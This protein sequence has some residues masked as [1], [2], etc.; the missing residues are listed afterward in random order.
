MLASQA[1]ITRCRS[2]FQPPSGVDA[3][4]TG[5]AMPPM[6]PIVALMLGQTGWITITLSPGS[7]IAS[8]VIMM[9][10]MP[11]EVTTTF[12]AATS[13]AWRRENR[14]SQPLKE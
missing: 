13:L 5:L 12:S 6:M 11:D 14:A 1:S 3:S 8:M 10:L 7:T 4:D 2:S 9:A